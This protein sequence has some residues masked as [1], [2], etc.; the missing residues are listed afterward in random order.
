M[1][2]PFD[3]SEAQFQHSIRYL[4]LPNF[5]VTAELIMTVV[6]LIAS[7]RYLIYQIIIITNLFTA[8]YIQNIFK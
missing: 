8:Y 5:I 1:P 3:V 2:N 4:N 7:Y 6:Y